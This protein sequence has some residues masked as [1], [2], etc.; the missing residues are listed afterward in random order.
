MARK[1]RQVSNTGVYHVMLRG[2]DRQTVFKSRIDTDKF[3][4]LLSKYKKRFGF[5]IYAYCFMGNHVHLLLKER[6][7]GSISLFMKCLL[8]AYVYWYNAE[9]ERC[10]TLFQSRFRSEAVETPRYFQRVVRYIHRN[11]VKAR[12]CRHV[13]QYSGS[14]YNHFFASDPG[15][16]DR[17]DV[18]EYIDRSEFCEFNDAES[19][20]EIDDTCLDLSEAIPFRLTNEK[21][22]KIMQSVAE[23]FD[24]SLYGT[25]DYRVLSA[26]IRECRRRSMSYGQISRELSVNKGTLHRLDRASA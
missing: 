14:S 24:F 6:D 23:T 25:M 19:V 5:K 9:H 11:P 2:I 1:P 16:I 20:N 26:V 21:A 3:I 7:S 12:M 10:G 15:I 22:S 4:D 8:D 17:D 13:W 18:F